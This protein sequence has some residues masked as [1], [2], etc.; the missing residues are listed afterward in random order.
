VKWLA[1]SES[2]CAQLDSFST[3]S[4]RTG[5]SEDVR[6]KAHAYGFLK[7]RPTVG[8]NVHFAPSGPPLKSHS[9]A[10]HLSIDL[11]NTDWCTCITLCHPSRPDPFVSPVSR[12]SP[13]SPLSP[14]SPFRPSHPF[15]QERL[16]APADPEPQSV[17]AC[18]ALLESLERL[19]GLQD[20][21][22]TSAASLLDTPKLHRLFFGVLQKALLR[23]RITLLKHR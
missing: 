13:L 19:V 7:Q 15:P 5:R 22:A 4:M 23:E 17:P 10:G 6:A 20:L 21:A 2:N 9:L 1:R 11:D 14:F 8:D 3:N 12:G 18:P 16:A